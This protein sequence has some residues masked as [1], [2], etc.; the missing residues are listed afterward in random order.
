MRLSLPAGALVAFGLAGSMLA[1]PGTSGVAA[2]AGPAAPGTPHPAAAGVATHVIVL[3][4]RGARWDTFDGTSSTGA[5]GLTLASSLAALSVRSAASQTCPADA[6][7]TIGTGSR[8][9]HPDGC[10]A[11][12]T[13]SPAGEVAGFADLARANLAGPYAAK[14]GAFAEALAGDDQ[15]ATA[16]GPLAALAAAHPDGRLDSYVADP[17]ALTDKDLLTCG[18]TLVDVPELPA[19]DSVIRHVLDL[20]MGN[21]TLG[22][23]SR[24]FLVGTG[25]GTDHLA[26]AA[27]L[28]A[29]FAP[30]LMTS[31]EVG[32]SPY[33]QLVDVPATVLAGFSPDIAPPAGFLGR[34]AAVADVSR[35]FSQ[36]L[37]AVR[38]AA[39]AAE[40]RTS[41]FPVFVA[42][43]L[44]SQLAG[45]V[46]LW[47]LWRRAGPAA[48]AR[49]RTLALAAGGLGLA[50][51]GAPAASFLASLTRWQTSAAPVLLL[52]GATLAATVGLAATAA[53]AR[54]RG[55]LSPVAAIAA[56]GVLVL[57]FDV[58]YSSRLQFNAVLGY[59]AL[60]A[61][62]FRG[63]GNLASGIFVALVL[64]TLAVVA[65][66]RE[67]TR[68]RVAAIGIGGA[69]AAAAL[70]APMW[71]ADVGG[72][73]ALLPALAVLGLLATGRRVSAA[74]LAGAGLAAVIVV[75]LLGLL[76]AA[77]PADSRTHL[78]RFVASLGDGTVGVTLRRRLTA[79][80]S[81]A[82]STWLAP[83]LLLVCAVAVVYV[84]RRPPAGV[85]AVFDTHPELRWSLLAVVVAAVI[86]LIVN[87]SG[88]SFL[89]GAALVAAPAVGAG[90][91]Y[92]WLAGHEQRRGTPALSDAVLP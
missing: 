64:L 11:T 71:G 35:S 14:A 43:L 83:L 57:A 15:C 73:L 9:A 77:R 44:G 6:W 81:L 28:G 23:A 27:F 10:R 59:D 13:V 38:E 65:A 91:S 62:R 21:V 92:N 30:A 67:T 82:T 55:A 36:R 22:T 24:V 31:P 47:L 32:R 70:G 87:D 1:G 51:V 41:T 29:P 40:T 63:L 49:R 25:D 46:L 45:W 88:I 56:A 89:A 54:H 34:P 53:R 33:L 17:A 66:R 60:T 37:H 76:D 68:G 84:L 86:G 78:G 50:G 72:V 7:L 20:A 61:G 18:V 42:I 85:R 5:A 58:V 90:A 19:G 12:V 16:V 52:V 48:A 8:A 26:L 79:D 3:G 75:G 74:P 39:R 69:V 4:V 2:S 80:V